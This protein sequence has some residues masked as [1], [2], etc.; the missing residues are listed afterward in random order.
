MKNFPEGSGRKKSYDSESI[1]TENI[2]RE[3]RKKREK[4]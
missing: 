4:A 3:Q 1:V 2:Y